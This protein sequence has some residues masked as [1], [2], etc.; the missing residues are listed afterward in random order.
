[1][2][3]HDAQVIASPSSPP[4]LPTRTDLGADKVSKRYI[5]GWRAGPQARAGRYAGDGSICFV[6][7][8]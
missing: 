8:A 5:P 6:V 2:R 7:L 3:G 1:M 4:S